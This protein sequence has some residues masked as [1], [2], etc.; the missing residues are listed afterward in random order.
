MKS[1]RWMIARHIIIMIA[2]LVAIG[3]LGIWLDLGPV[4]HSVEAATAQ[5]SN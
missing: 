3:G 5:P 1:T 4:V 2:V